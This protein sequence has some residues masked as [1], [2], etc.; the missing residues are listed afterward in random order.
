MK[1]KLRGLAV[2]VAMSALRILGIRSLIYGVRFEVDREGGMR[3][4][5]AGRG[6]AEHRLHVARCEFDARGSRS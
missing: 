1:L 3:I 2:A 6:V 5:P 4:E